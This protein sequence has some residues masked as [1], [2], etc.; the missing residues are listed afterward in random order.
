MWQCQVRREI[1]KA[2]CA[3][4]IRLQRCPKVYLTVGNS[5]TAVIARSRGAITGNSLAPWFGQLMMEDAF[6]TAAPHTDPLNLSVMH[7]VLRPMAWSDNILAFGQ[8]VQVVARLLADIAEVLSTRHLA[9]KDGS[10][11]IVPASTRRIPCTYVRSRGSNFE[12][13]DEM[14]CL[15]YWIACNGDTTD[16]H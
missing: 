6:I 3:A 2:W 13:I 1:P 5:T 15:G 14:K 16:Q 9:I 4:A 8:S 10:C 12:V 11:Q 7:V